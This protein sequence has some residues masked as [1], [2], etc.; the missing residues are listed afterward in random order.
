MVKRK[1]V[2]TETETEQSERITGTAV[3]NTKSRI[4]KTAA[5]ETTEIK[6][7]S[8]EALV[9]LLWL[10]KGVPENIKRCPSFSYSEQAEIISVIPLS[11][12]ARAA[13]FLLKIPRII[14]Y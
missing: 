10:W 5:K 8:R 9:E 4:N 2:R 11:L 13:P 1:A 6:V 14:T 12:L 3:L 7:I